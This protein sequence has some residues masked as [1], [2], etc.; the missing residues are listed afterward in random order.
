VHVA[1]ADVMS[2]KVAIDLCSWGCSCCCQRAVACCPLLQLVEH[3]VGDVVLDDLTSSRGNSRLRCR[4][5]CRTIS[6]ATMSKDTHK[7]AS[8]YCCCS[9]CNFF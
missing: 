9:C 7:K 1:T 6:R 3:R 2:G 8:Y 5:T 4:T